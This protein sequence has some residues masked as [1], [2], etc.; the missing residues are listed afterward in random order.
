MDN[1]ISHIKNVLATIP[2]EVWG[3][4]VSGLFLIS[5]AFLAYK[6]GLQTY[7]RQ[8]E[9]ELILKRYLAEGIDNI[10][11]LTDRTSQ[12]FLYNYFKASDMV[13]QLEAL[14]K[15]DL[16]TKF[17]KAPTFPG[18]T[19]FFKLVYLTGDED[20]SQSFY[21]FL[22]FVNSEST[23]LDTNFRS[24]VSKAVNALRDNK[25]RT[26]LENMSQEFSD[27]LKADLKKSY[28]KFMKYSYIFE[29]LQQIASILEK[30][31]RLTWADL[32][33]F[34]ERGEIKQSVERIKKKRVELKDK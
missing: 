16:S 10:L 32:D 3:S 9:H 19:P 31:T 33:K 11:E 14:Q 23:Y 25:D 29:E 1:Y 24:L 6:Y 7:F 26:T 13:G 4:I 2:P 27:V 12:V 30:E 21:D 20:L 22:S 15:V 17:R 28:N 34:K 8:R 18:F 5:T